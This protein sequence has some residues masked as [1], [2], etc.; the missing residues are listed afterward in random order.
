MKTIALA[1]LFLGAS[2]SMTQSERTEVEST[3]DEF[4]EVERTDDEGLQLNEPETTDKEDVAKV[5]SGSKI[6]L[7]I[8]GGQFG[9]GSGSGGS[10]KLH[11]QN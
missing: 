6:C 4:T 3:E 5:S 8:I 2:L 9:S 11:C 7:N 10:G 1:V